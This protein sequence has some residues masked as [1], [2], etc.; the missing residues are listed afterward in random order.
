MAMLRGV[1]VG[2]R[3]RRLRNCRPRLR[4]VAVMMVPA[5][6]P[7][8]GDQLGVVLFGHAGELLQEADGRPQLLIAV[9]APGRH[10]GHSDPVFHNPEQLR[11]AVVTGRMREIGRLRV[12]S[13]RY[14]ALGN[15][16][17]AVADGA[18]CSEMLRAYQHFGRIVEPLG[19][20]DA[21]SLDFDR[22]IAR[23][24]ED[25]AHNRRMWVA[26]GDVEKTR[27][28]E[29]DP[30]NGNKDERQENPGEEVPHDDVPIYNQI[31]TPKTKRK[32]P[33]LSPA[34]WAKFAVC[35]NFPS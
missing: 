27:I 18:V 4:L 3:A 1:I 29:N 25:P 17:R 22:A 13:P 11:G 28:D 12:Q 32:S 7:A 5:L 14:V 30:A 35:P 9:I 21:R 26:G 31:R 10:T 8:C 33:V 15:P 16:W 20:R 6:R 34:R 24:L 2:W 23:R 19:D